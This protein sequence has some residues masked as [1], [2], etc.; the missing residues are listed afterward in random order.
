MAAVLMSV[1]LTKFFFK[2]LAGGKFSLMI[3]L[4]LGA[5]AN[6]TTSRRRRSMLEVDI[7][8]HRRPRRLL[9]SSKSR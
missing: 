2:A 1:I 6:L 4:L 7:L 5:T 8:S 3:K 9:P